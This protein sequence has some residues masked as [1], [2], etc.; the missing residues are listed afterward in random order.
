MLS[1]VFPQ[2]HRTYSVHF[3][4]KETR[5]VKA[6]GFDI[7]GRYAVFFNING[8]TLAIIDATEVIQQ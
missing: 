6:I 3:K 2:S 8:N 1:P 7:K 4:D 5:T